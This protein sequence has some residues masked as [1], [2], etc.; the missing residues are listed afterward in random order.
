MFWTGCEVADLKQRQKLTAMDHRNKIQ[1][2]VLPTDDPGD[3]PD[4]MCEY[5]PCTCEYGRMCHTTP[6]TQKYG[7]S[8]EPVVNSMLVAKYGQLRKLK[9]F[10]WESPQNF[11]TS[12][13]G[14]AER[15]GFFARWGPFGGQSCAWSHGAD[16]PHFHMQTGK[17]ANF[18]EVWV[19]RRTNARL[20]VDGPRSAAG[21]LQN[22]PGTPAAQFPLGAAG[23]QSALYRAHMGGAGALYGLQLKKGGEDECA[24][25]QC[26]FW[27]LGCLPWLWVSHCRRYLAVLR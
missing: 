26:P 19:F 20:C 6:T 12:M 17:P 9:I 4:C 16:P 18:F 22:T 10:L 1:S 8:V 2:L 3:A 14:T 25:L 21:H 27:A 15:H 13:R 11:E 24:H 7:F 23:S 5:G